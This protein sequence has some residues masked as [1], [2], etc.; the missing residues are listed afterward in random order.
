GQIR[1]MLGDSLMAVVAQQLLRT[2]DG[3]GRCAANEILLDSPA[4]ANL[5]REGKISQIPSLIQ[6]RTAEGMQTMDQALMKLIK[7]GKITSEAAYEK[8]NDKKLFAKRTD[9]GGK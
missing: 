9:E 4:L 7:E 1:S 5:I 8:A 2:S 6:T 3:K